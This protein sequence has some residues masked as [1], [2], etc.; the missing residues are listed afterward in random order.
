MILAI[1]TAISSHK[2]RQ[3]YGRD[4]WRIY[5]PNPL[6]LILAYII[7]AYIPL[8][9]E[10]SPISLLILRDIGHMTAQTLGEK[11]W[12]KYFGDFPGGTVV[13]TLG[14]QCSGMG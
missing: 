5:G 8:E 9:L 12:I 6:V 13:K 1:I 3:G 10:P 7:G 14:S 2:K 11:K 4:F